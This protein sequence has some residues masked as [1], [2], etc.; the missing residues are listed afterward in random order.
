MPLI[1]LMNFH[2]DGLRLGSDPEGRVQVEG[3]A[4]GEILITH[5]PHD[6]LGT[7]NK[8]GF[9]TPRP[10]A[11]S[12]PMRAK[13]G[14]RGLSIGRDVMANTTRAGFRIPEMTSGGADLYLSYLMVG[15]S[16]SP[17]LSR[18]IFHALMR[19]AS[20]SGA[21]AAFDAILL[22]NRTKYL[23]LLETLEQHHGEMIEQ[24]RMMAYFQLEAMTHC[25]G[26]RDL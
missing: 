22:A 5:G 7:F 26:S 25:V 16:R 15:H 19:E 4:Q 6:S 13:V 8:F 3:E 23:C 20:A 18:A 12:L 21:E 11:Y 9:A 24:L 10:Y 17:R 14:S 1:D 2:S